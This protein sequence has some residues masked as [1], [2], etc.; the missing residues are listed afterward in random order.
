L[1]HIVQKHSDLALLIQAWPELPEHIK[2]AIKTLIQTQK[3]G[4]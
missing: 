2:T 1:A 3:K 4:D